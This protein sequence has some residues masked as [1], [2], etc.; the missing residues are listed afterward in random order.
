[1]TLSISGL[2]FSDETEMDD[3]PG[4]EPQPFAHIPAPENNTGSSD[5]YVVRWQ[6]IIEN[7]TS[8][9]DLTMKWNAERSLRGNIEWR[10]KATP[11]RLKDAVTRRIEQ[12]K[13]KP[14]LPTQRLQAEDA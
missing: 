13:P 11:A 4:A 10:D 8:A 12:L 14:D 5:A 3:V 9:E 7:A 6:A 2:G 1:V